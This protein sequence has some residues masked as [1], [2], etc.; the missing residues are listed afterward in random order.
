MTISIQQTV[1]AVFVNG[2]QI[3]TANDV[4]INESGDS[5]CRVAEFELAE[6]PEVEPE[7]GDTVL[8]QWLDYDDLIS[9]DAFGGT[10]NAIEINS[11]PWSMV[12]RCTDQLE[13]LRRVPSGNLSF[14]GQTVTE[15]MQEIL[16]ACNVDYDLS[17]LVNIPYVLGQEVAINWQEDIPGSQVASDLNSVF[18]L[19]LQTIGNNRVIW[20]RPDLPPIDGT[21]QY[22]TFT[23]GVDADWGSNRRSHGDRDQI[24]SFFQVRGAAIPCGPKDACT[25]TPFAKASDFNPQIGGKKIRTATQA[26]SS[27]MIQDESMA[28]FI[29]R[30][31]MREKNRFPDQ[32]SVDTLYDPNLHPGTKVGLI[33]PTYGIDAVTVRRC[34]ATNVDVSGPS[35]TLTLMCGDP[36]S[37]GTVITGVDKVCN[38]VH[39]G[40]DMPGTFTP[41]DFEFPPILP[42]LEFDPLVIDFTPGIG[43]ISEASDD[44]GPGG[45]PGGGGGLVSPVWTI[46]FGNWSLVSGGAHITFIGESDEFCVEDPGLPDAG[47]SGSAWA[48][49]DGLPLDGS[50]RFRASG[51]VNTIIGASDPA[52]T[53]GLSGNDGTGDFSGFTINADEIDYYTFA[54]YQDSDFVDATGGF[55]FSVDWNPGTDTFAVTIDIGAG[56]MVHSW[57]LGAWASA[58]RYFVINTNGNHCALEVDVDDIVLTVGE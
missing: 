15:T 41:P 1:F 46:L 4:V 28:E 40:V 23:K 8:I 55:T 5:L 47:F 14:T 51:T 48:D 42:G 6:Q 30:R 7:I 34:T 18:G 2:T 45:D 19:Y 37:E 11:E 10:I 44:G 53:I 35:S 38:D 21:G 36:G 54:N 52:I 22:R 43:V 57:P 24:Q 50:E 58:D 16:D 3:H 20:F 17:D 39:T 12:I 31:H 25:C 56:P 32:A 27:D 9:V 26:I 29:V 13:K 33:D 49:G